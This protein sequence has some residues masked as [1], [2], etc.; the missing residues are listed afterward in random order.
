MNEQNDLV[1]TVVFK[2]LD[3]IGYLSDTTM[4]ILVNSINF[5]TDD[6]E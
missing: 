4:N 5:D 2:T 6:K 3:I 1:M